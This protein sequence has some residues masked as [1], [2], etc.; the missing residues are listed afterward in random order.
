M[1]L[2]LQLLENHMQSLRKDWVN[3]SKVVRVT[4]LG[5]NQDISLVLGTRHWSSVLT[6]HKENGPWKPTLVGSVV[7]DS[8]ETL[9]HEE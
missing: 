4:F 9:L 2:S 8:G 7:K 3:Y 5:P 6:R 1:E